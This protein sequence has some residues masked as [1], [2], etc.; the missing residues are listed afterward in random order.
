MI[1]FYWWKFLDVCD[2]DQFIFSSVQSVETLKRAEKVAP[3]NPSI[4]PSQ[5]LNKINLIK[6]YAGH[7]HF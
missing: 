6:I 2:G 3:I 5:F 7:V 1:L 4:F